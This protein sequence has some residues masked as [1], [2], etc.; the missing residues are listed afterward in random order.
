MKKI[1]FCALLIVCFLPSIGFSHSDYYIIKNGLKYHQSIKNQQEFQPF[2]RVPFGTNDD[3]VGGSQEDKDSISEG[4]PY[5]FRV[6]DHEIWILD[7]INKYLK[8]FT[9]KGK[10]IHKISLNSYGKVITD[11][12]FGPQNTFWLL[13]PVEGNVF[14]LDK[15]GKKLCTLSGFPQATKIQSA[16]NSIY[17]L[18]PLMKAIYK[19]SP[20]KRKAYELSRH[21]ECTN[22]ISLFENE[23]QKLYEFGNT[24]KTATLYSREGLTKVSKKKILS[25]PYTGIDEGNNCKFVRQEILGLDNSKRLYFRLTVNDDYG[26]IYQDRLYRYDPAI[27]NVK[28][29]EILSKPSFPLTPSLPRKAVV[30]PAGKVIVFYSSEKFYYLALYTFPES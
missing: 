7:S 21:I 10:L 20:G 25:I 12:A 17:I 28:H 6:K 3:S 4:V 5:A 15:S 1:I 14:Q 22:R 19:F 11:F 16:E 9:Q 24:D 30:S 18:S 8:C 29:I 26:V 13:A 2:F 27:N 23:A